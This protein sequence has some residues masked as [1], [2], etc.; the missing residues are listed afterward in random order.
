[1]HEAQVYGIGC[2]EDGSSELRTEPPGRE[3]QDAEPA[4]VMN[5]A[6]VTF[7]TAQ[8]LELRGTLLKLTRNLVIFETYG[9][10]PVLRMSEVLSDFTLRRYEQPLYTGRAI[11]SNLLQSGS[12]TVCEA[13]LSDAWVNGSS[14]A[15]GPGVADAKTSFGQF[16]DYWGKTY[17]VLPEFKV[18]ISD[19][20]S[21]LLDLRTWLE[22]IELVIRS[23]PS[24]NRSA[25]DRQWLEALT[26]E[27]TAAIGDLFGRFEEVAQKVEPE[28]LPAHVAFSRQL[29][30]PIILASPFV[31]RTLHKPLGYAGDYEMVNMIMRDPYEGASLFAKAFNVCALSRPP[32][33]AHRNRLAYLTDKLVQETL[34]KL[35]MGQKAKFLS[36]GC[37]P[38]HE[39]R[40]F[41]REHACSDKVE[42]TLV[43]FDLETVDHV[44]RALADLKRASGRATSI[45]VVKRSVQ[46]M[47]KQWAKAIQTDAGERYDMVYCAGLFDYL[48]NPLIRS[49]MGY[50]DELLGPGGLQLV[51]NVD[52]HGNSKEMEYFLDWHLIYRNAQGM[53]GLIPSRISPEDVAVI[54]EPSGLNVF[55]EIRKR[56]S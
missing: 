31:Y 10:E 47:L 7:R 18:V 3:A 42:F 5:D 30:H 25:I 36:V 6:M 1:M 15:P 12:C 28:T 4:S 51:T 11:V 27:T 17:R 50:F 38:A 22:Q 49:L 35:S 52:F 16:L 53:L 29:L 24:G 2:S 20:H 48:P 37:G 40:R 14:T 23:D 44:T 33:I 54:H 46:Q 21:F 34:R 43:D 13:L 9:P 32:I 56:K 26:P 45:Q 8:G 41:I 39:V 19:I 55:L